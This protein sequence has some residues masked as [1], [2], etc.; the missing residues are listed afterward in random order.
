MK[1]FIIKQMS[2]EKAKSLGIDTWEVWDSGPSVTE[3][4]FP[5]QETCYFLEGELLVTVGDTVHLI[6]PNMLVSFPKGLPC[7]W[8]I[9]HYVKKAYKNNFEWE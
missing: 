2:W 4:E 8:E 3:G 6:Q 5:E 9:P 1:G 7:K